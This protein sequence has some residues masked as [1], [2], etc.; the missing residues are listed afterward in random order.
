M[1]KAGRSYQWMAVASVG[2]NF[3]QPSSSA[4]EGWYKS[5]I[6]ACSDSACMLTT[7]VVVVG[8]G[9]LYQC[10][11]VE[12][13]KVGRPG[14]GIELLILRTHGKDQVDAGPAGRWSRLL[15]V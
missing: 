2:R 13:G 7:L 3:L 5:S 12:E 8:D 1:R 11:G 10:V 4:T 6:S 14:L 9:D 15:L